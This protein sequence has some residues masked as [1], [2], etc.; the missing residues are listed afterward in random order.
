[1]VTK[2]ISQGLAAAALIAGLAIGSAA[3]AGAYSRDTY[4][5][6]IN[7][8]GYID[9]CCIS[10]HGEIVYDQEGY[11]YTCW[12]PLKEAEN[13]PH[14]PGQP[15]NPMIPVLRGVNSGTLAS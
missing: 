13:V 15:S 10:A 7:N 11:P 12:E 2:R 4:Y 5:R 3:T 8:F 14:S 6:C 1:M 9:E